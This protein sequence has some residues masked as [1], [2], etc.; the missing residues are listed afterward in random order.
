MGKPDSKI[1]EYA[2]KL[3]STWAITNYHNHEH[4]RPKK[5]QEEKWTPNLATEQQGKIDSKAAAGVQPIGGK[6]RLSTIMKRGE[7]IFNNKAGCCTTCGVGTAYGLIKQGLAGPGKTRIELV[8]FTTKDWGHVFMVVDREGAP[9]TP[10]KIK[11][12]KLAGESWKTWGAKAYVFDTW[13]GILGQDPIDESPTKGKPFLTN[14][15]NNIDVF[16]DSQ[17]PEED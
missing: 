7:E 3:A 1:R 2:T 5:K 9:V 12:G 14:L 15:Y 11:P 4:L 16:Y 8:G 17:W 10:G 13:I 6:V